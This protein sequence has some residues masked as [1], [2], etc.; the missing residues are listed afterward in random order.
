MNSLLST[1]Q[2][3]LV[4]LSLIVGLFPVISHAQSPLD[5]ISPKDLDTKAEV[6]KIKQ[7]GQQSLN[8]QI[9]DLEK[10]NTALTKDIG[11]IQASIAQIE[12]TINTNLITIQTIE[13][14]PTNGKNVKDEIIKLEK[15]NEANSTT[16]QEQ[17]K[18][19]QAKEAKIGANKTAIEEIKTKIKTSQSDLTKEINSFQ[20]DILAFVIT[21]SRFI[22]L[23][24][25]YWVIV[26][27]LRLFMRRYILNESVRNTIALI[28]VFAAII[29]TFIT[30]FIAF[31][32]NTTYLGPTLGVFSAAMVVALQDF[33]SSFFA[34]V[35]IKARGPFT[36]NDTI[37]IPTTNGRMKGVVTQIG[38]FRTRIKE[39][40]GG[41][42]PNSEQFTGEMIFFPN[43]LILKQGFRNSTFDNKMLWHSLEI[44][45]TFESN[46]ELAR[47]IIEKISQTEFEY[48][49]D[50]KDIY[51]DDVFNL[52]SFYRPRIY[53]ELSDH[54][55]KFI[56]W[57]AC[58]IGMFREISEKI[59]GNILRD[60][61]HRDVDLSYQ[62]TRV[63]HLEESQHRVTDFNPLIS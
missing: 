24:I 15:L 45:I 38:F 21:V 36:I 20:V 34:W 58:R 54:G 23:I 7:D 61:K 33:I 2:K 6:I 26:Q 60:F 22:A 63:V 46:F 11:A 39:K 56:I 27:L 31:A 30:I 10:E 57:V 25:L 40:F 50:H 17:I 16:K 1:V 53:M 14:T 5:I 41:D 18:S 12:A 28:L 52:K 4:I 49:L 29:A 59:I 51:L 48:M 35:V 9:T 8:S 62:T 13:N 47:N 43:N 37:E 55:P 3:A 42:S 32:G 19:I 44:S